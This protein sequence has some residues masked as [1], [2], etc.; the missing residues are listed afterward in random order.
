[1]QI[2]IDIPDHIYNIL[3][4]DKILISNVD[5]L[6]I[7]FKEL[8]K[9]GTQLPKD[10]TNGDMI[11]TLF[12]DGS[13]VKGASIYVMNDNKSNVF[14]DFDWWNA[15]YKVDCILNSAVLP[16]GHEMIINVDE[17]HPKKIEYKAE[18]EK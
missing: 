13:Q 8:I 4:D 17:L 9:K 18:S 11:K 2:I 10:A 3:K 12:P 16:K 14:Y 1:M 7:V 6:A 15:L 5:H